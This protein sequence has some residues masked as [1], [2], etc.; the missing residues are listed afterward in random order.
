MMKNEKGSI[1][2]MMIA[3]TFVVAYLLV[4]LATQIEVKVASYERTRIYMTMNILEQE[5][6]ERLEYFLATTNVEDYFSEVWSLQNGA[7]MS[8]NGRK[9]DDSFD[10]YYQIVYNEHVYSQRLSAYFVEGLTFSE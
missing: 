8:I 2:P 5:G 4:T 7:V 3:I 6:L 9:R 1:L 10:F